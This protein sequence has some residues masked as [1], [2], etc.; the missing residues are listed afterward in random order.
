VLQL[1]GDVEG[2]LLLAGLEGALGDPVLAG[3]PK[4]LMGAGNT[5][6][7]PVASERLG[8]RT[9]AQRHSSTKPGGRGWAHDA[10]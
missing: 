6:D 1:N 9:S 3:N 5:A 4:T 10:R 8:P 7:P 2:L